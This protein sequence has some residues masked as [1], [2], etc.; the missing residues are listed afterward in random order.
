MLF[1]IVLLMLHKFKERKIQFIFFIP[2]LN[3]MQHN[4]FALL[5][6]KQMSEIKRRKKKLEASTKNICQ[7]RRKK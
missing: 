5:S 1:K 4:T 7:K 3:V 6:R 2:C